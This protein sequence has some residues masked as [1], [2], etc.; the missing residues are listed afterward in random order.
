MLD[1]QMHTHT[2]THTHSLDSQR[3]DLMFWNDLI[4]SSDKTTLKEY[5]FSSSLINFK[6]KNRTHSYSLWTNEWFCSQFVIH[7][8]VS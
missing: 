3:A 7:D 4:C 1:W 8:L 5:L 2:Q 6:S